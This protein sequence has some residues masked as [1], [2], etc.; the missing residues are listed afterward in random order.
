MSLNIKKTYELRTAQC[1]GILR[2]IIEA[3]II[4]TANLLFQKQSLFETILEHKKH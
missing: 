2:T 3:D 4:L 1:T